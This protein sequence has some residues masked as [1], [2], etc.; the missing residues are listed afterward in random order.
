MGLV[1]TTF[2]KMPG[3]RGDR[4]GQA[5]LAFVRS[6]ERLASLPD[7][8]PMGS[9]AAGKLA[10][11][12]G[13]WR[14]LCASA[15]SL[16][17]D[18]DALVR[19][20]FE[21]N[22]Q[23][24]MVTADGHTQGLFTGYFEIELNGAWLKKAPYT[25]PIYERP[26]ELVEVN[27]GEF[28]PAL[29]GQRLVGKTVGGSLKPF[30]RRAKIDGGSLAGRGIELLWIDSPVDAFFLHVQGSGRVRMDDGSLVR[31]G[32]AGRNGHPYVSIGRI[33]IDRGEMMAE[34]VS[35]Q[36]I[37][38]WIRDH[39]DEGGRLMAMNPSYIFFRIIDGA[40]KSV[41]PDRGPVGAQGA[42]LT[43]G[44]SLAVDPRH[45]PF[46]VPVWLDT[47]DPLEPTQ[48]LSRLLVAQDTGSAIRGPVRGDLF[49][50]FGD[51]A[52]TRAGLMKHPG[53]Y[54]LLLPRR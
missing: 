7:S 8:R 23:P 18:N 25:T 47:V 6:C 54:F 15:A 45:V 46:G 49:W 13:D 44:R 19:A 30:D 24:Y 29:A 52:A 1:A 5:V 2:D 10:G 26:P 22:F 20:Y 36:S 40:L 3:W 17:K 35:M 53:R 33:L 41:P 4:Q 21:S 42:P 32:F 16:P 37:R 43:P 31:I 48:P 27:L 38:A 39:P 11:T 50:G 9:G 51:D 14:G 34:R 12:V 28:N